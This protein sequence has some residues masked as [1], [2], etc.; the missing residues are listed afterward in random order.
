[1]SELLKLTLVGLHERHPGLTQPLADSYTEAACVCWSRHHQPPVVVAVRDGNADHRRM[2]DFQVPDARMRRAH[3]NETD[4]TEAGA[5][6]VSL[7]TVEAVAGLVAV[8]R[9]ETL[10]GADW[11]VAPEG[12]L[13]DDLENCVRLEVSGT[14]TGGSAEI[15]RRLHEKVAQAARGDSNL[16]AIASV[17]GFRA[18]EIAISSLQ[19][20]Q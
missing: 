12:S 1:M 5:Y 9:A 18:L 4:A 19:G 15:I 11:Y 3:A 8:G 17:V 7:A 6:G 16:P 13:V 20:Q 14:S 10:T 2:V